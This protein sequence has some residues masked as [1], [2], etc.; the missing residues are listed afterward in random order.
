MMQNKSNASEQSCLE[1]ATVQSAAVAS[2]PLVDKRFLDGGRQAPPHYRGYGGHGDGCH[3]RPG[4]RGSNYNAGGLTDVDVICFKSRDAQHGARTHKG[5]LRLHSLVTAHWEEYTESPR[6]EKLAV[7]KK[8]VGI[9]HNRGGRFLTSTCGKWEDVGNDTAIRKVRDALSGVTA[10]AQMHYDEGKVTPPN[11]RQSRAEST[12][13]Q[14]I[15]NEI[16]GLRGKR[17]Q[18]NETNTDER[19]TNYQR[20]GGRGDRDRGGRGGGRGYQSYG[21]RS[22]GGRGEGSIEIE[23]QVHNGVYTLFGVDVSSPSRMFTSQE[24][25]RLGSRGQ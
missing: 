11:K 8:V 12:N 24:M 15:P 10:V 2:T 25:S 22:H 5:N 14:P 18:P 16:F 21:G 9:V 23:V 1:S 13:K 4:G 6:D 20:S 7:A 3:P 19:S 17:R